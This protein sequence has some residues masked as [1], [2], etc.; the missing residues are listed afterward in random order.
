MSCSDKATKSG[1]TGAQDVVSAL[2]P[3]ERKDGALV[4][5]EGLLQLS[6]RRPDPREAVV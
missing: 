4:L 6:R 2:V 3:L 5:A 1:L